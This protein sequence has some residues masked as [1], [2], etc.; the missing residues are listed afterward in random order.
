MSTHSRPCRSISRRAALA[1][2]LGVAFGAASALAQ[3]GAPVP[4]TK[5]VTPGADRKGRTSSSQNPVIVFVHG[6][7]DTGALW[8]TTLWRFESN[9]V[10]RNLL[11]APDLPYPSARTDDSKPQP[12]RSSTAEQRDELAGIVSRALKET[13]RRKLVLIGSSRGGNAIRSYVRDGGGKDT[14]SHAILCGTPNHGVVALDDYLVGSEF[15]GK[16][17]FLRRLNEGDEI[18]PGPQ[19]LTLRSDALDKFAQPDG[20]WVNRPGKPT[21]VGAESPELKGAKNVV[22]PGLDHRE[23]AFDK[24]AFREMFAFVM[25]RE[26]ATLFI[27]PERQPTL[28]GT[29]TGLVDGTYTNLPVKDALV[30]IFEVDPRTGARRGSVAAH[31]KATGADGRWGPFGAHFE[32]HYEFVLTTSGNPITHTYRS[33]FTRSSTIVH[34]RPG[35][36]GRDDASAGQVV[37]LSRPRGYFG[38]NRDKVTFDGKPATLPDNP[39]PGASTVRLAVEAGPS[40]TVVCQFN[41]ETIPV[42]TAPTKEGRLV[43]AELHN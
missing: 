17:P 12:F 35:Q 38:P 11:Y 31:R 30:E 32:A 6:N 1:G 23:V 33:P 5:G 16:G 37:Y 9:G 40:R 36:F 28:D 26:P 14:V 41:N 10:P 8:H 15:N 20:F 43:I 25:G 22:L 21:G 3:Q 18:A 4:Q 39:V 42:R 19:W 24:R 2:G 34:L 27:V 29:V 13:K 7:G